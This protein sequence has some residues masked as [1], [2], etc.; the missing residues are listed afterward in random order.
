MHRRIRHL[1]L[2]L[3]CC[4]FLG[5]AKSPPP[6]TPTDE[7]TGDSKALS[8]TPRPVLTPAAAPADVFAVVRFSSPASFADTAGRW[9]NVTVDWRGL[10]RDVA[11]PIDQVVL[12]DAPIEAA[13]MLDDSSRGS[14]KM[15]FAVSIG[16]SSFDG[17]R[18]FLESKGAAMTAA[19][20]GSYRAEL[21]DAH[22]LLAFAMGSAPARL[23][24]SDKARAVDQ[25]APYMTRGLP[26]EALV[27]AEV[28]AELRAEP[29]RRR[30]GRQVQMVK[31]GVPFVLRELELD[32][33]QFDAVMSETLYALADEVVLLADDLDAV[34]LIGKLEPRAETLDFSASIKLRSQ[35]SWFGQ[36]L[37]EVEPQMTGPSESF[38]LLPSTAFEASYQVRATGEKQKV[39]TDGLVKVMDG[40][41]SYLGVPG[42]LRE[43]TTRAVQRFFFE[44]GAGAY[45][46]GEGQVPAGKEPAEY[47]LMTL[48]GQTQVDQLLR[49]LFLVYSHPASRKTLEA[50]FG[51]GKWPQ[52]VTKRPSAG[53]GLPANAVIYEVTLPAELESVLTPKGKPEGPRKMYVTTV[54]HAGRTWIAAAA[55]EKVL[56]QQ[57]TFVTTSSDA[58]T[59]ASNRK[60]DKLR[61]QQALGAG[62]VTLN[63]WLVALRDL[64]PDLLP[65][66]SRLEHGGATPILQRI[67]ASQ[68]GSELTYSL[69]L[70]KPVLADLASLVLAAVANADKVETH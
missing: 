63:G 25:L 27:K 48:S 37:R 29:W 38:W 62:F 52:I 33:P 56:Y 66:S 19:G 67:Y 14:P 42:R 21:G 53:S 18:Q 47:H 7:H 55:E 70:P 59:L 60:V 36:W 61:E 24:C 23:V 16:L 1:A 28:F 41:L 13:A 57:I 22:C 49:Q 9:S 34:R 17:A 69:S 3:L 8:V 35:R 20:P 6:R 11:G 26:G 51:A 50:K 30:F 10:L 58:T 5:C 40:G 15:L 46:S 64:A 43:D 44:A 65:L 68:A 32:H 12:L 31:L 4:G 54:N 39:F 2:T 45:A